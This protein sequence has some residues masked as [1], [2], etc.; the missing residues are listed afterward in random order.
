MLRRLSAVFIQLLLA[1]GLT[2][3]ARAQA[4]LGPG[5]PVDPGNNRQ[6]AEITVT[7]GSGGVT[8]YISIRDALPGAP[9]SPGLGGSA[10]PTAGPSCTAAAVNIGN[11]SLAWIREGLAAHP[12]TVPWMVR[13][14]NGFTGIAWIPT[15]A[16]APPAVVVGNPPVAAVDPVAVAAEVLGIVPL[17]PI[18]VG[19][20]PGTGLV[21]LPSWFW[22]DG[23]DGRRLS[24]SRAVGL[25]VVE[26]E[27]WPQN[28]HWSFG[29]GASLDTLSVGRAYP[30][31]S[32]VRH[33]YERSSLGAGGAFDTRLEITFAAQ[34]RVNGG[35]W[36]PL[37]PV[38][39]TYSRAYPVQQLQ[40]VLTGR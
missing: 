11:A 29:D 40:S 12:D 16:T 36:T 31:E 28:Y 27:I 6:V 8:I 14:D 20:N 30:E 23:Y 34:F 4:P 26:V 33:A 10:P 35:P 17:P 39:Q 18:R 32:D 25:V 9:G 7:S 21:A 1:A 19:A 15:S 13:C 2:S 5:A 22:I 24:G 3:A 38:T 37:P